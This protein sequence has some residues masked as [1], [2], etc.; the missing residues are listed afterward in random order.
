[1]PYK[2]HIR[3]NI[4]D[5]SYVRHRIEGSKL[6]YCLISNL[7]RKQKDGHNNVANTFHKSA[8]QCTPRVIRHSDVRSCFE[9]YPYVQ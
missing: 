5:I 6:L 7:I 8:P 3:Q 1:M 4:D 9:C 2:A